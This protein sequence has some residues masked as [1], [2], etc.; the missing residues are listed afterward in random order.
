MNG[1]KR[2]WVVLIAG[3]LILEYSILSYILFGL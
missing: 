2:G 1:M 3:A